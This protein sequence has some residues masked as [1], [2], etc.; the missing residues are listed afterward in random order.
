MEKFIR[1]NKFTIFK[2]Y[3]KE[4]IEFKANIYLFYCLD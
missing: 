3:V 2:D 1:L 4:I